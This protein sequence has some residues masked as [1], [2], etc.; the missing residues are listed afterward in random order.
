MSA[1]IAGGLLT[2]VGLTDLLAA[3]L[4][5]AVPLLLA[6]LG[7][8]LSEQ[9][10]VLNIGLEGMMLTGAYVGFLVAYETGVSSLGFL[11]GAIA[12]GAV[13]AI[14][15]V[16]CVRLL[17]DQIVIGIGI[18]LAAEGVTSVLHGSQFGTSY[19][20]LPAA[21]VTS[22]PLLERIPVLGPSLFEQSLLVYLGLLAVPATAYWLRHTTAGLQLRAAGQRPQ[23]LDAVGVDVVRTRTLGVLAAGLLAG[24]GGAYLAIAVSGV[25]V[26]FLTQG[27]GFIAIVICML[28][29]GR[30]LLALVGSLVFGL[31][32][33]LQTALQLEGVEIPNDVVD[34]LPFAAV[35]AALVLFARGDHLPPALGR[36]FSRGADR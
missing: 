6:S 10:G 30:P 23:A 24:L 27:Q 4:L 17:L 28:A 1:I 29:R 25:F 15:V 20:R 5:A 26:P 22:I 13:S 14:V 7:E 36:P 8:L 12:G 18:T 16:L 34:M 2:E 32:L 19:P 31:S 21:P 11:A 9:G 3:A 33:S 35:L